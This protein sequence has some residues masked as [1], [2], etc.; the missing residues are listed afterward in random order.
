MMGHAYAT[1]DHLRT[2][3][4]M[5]SSGIR[6]LLIY[7]A[8]Y[9]CSHWVEV[10]ADQWPDDVRLSDLE[11]R[12]VCT[13]CGQRGGDV[14]PNWTRESSRWGFDCVFRLRLQVEVS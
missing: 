8:D 7:C 12:F 4:E 11:P 2:F 9:H 10:R 6:S 14:R 3:A 1:K 5:R 13:A